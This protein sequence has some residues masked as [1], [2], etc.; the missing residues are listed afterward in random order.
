MQPYSFKRIK[1]TKDSAI[2]VGKSVELKFEMP[3]IDE[4]TSEYFTKNNGKKIFS[5]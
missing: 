5:T 2:A 3:E 1:L 4:S